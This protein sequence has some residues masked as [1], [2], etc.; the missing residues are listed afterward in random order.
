MKK[1]GLPPNSDSFIGLHLHQA[2]TRLYR[3]RYIDIPA[4]ARTIYRY[5]G[6]CDHDISIYHPC[7]PTSPASNCASEQ[8]MCVATWSQLCEVL[9]NAMND[10]GGENLQLELIT[11]PTGFQRENTT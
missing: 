7:R 8:R 11:A 4:G 10:G 3:A 5:T 9:V 2:E 1:L 6:Q